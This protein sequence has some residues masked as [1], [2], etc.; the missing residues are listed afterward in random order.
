MKSVFI[1]KTQV[2]TALEHFDW[3]YI[4][5]FN[6]NSLNISL[7]SSPEKAKQFE[8]YK[9]AEELIHDIFSKSTDQRSSIFQIEKVFIYD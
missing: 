4:E 6:S 1:I 7:Q 8:T 5:W 3:F 9:D 2:Q